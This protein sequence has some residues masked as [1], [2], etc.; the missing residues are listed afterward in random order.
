M[1]PSPLRTI[2]RK[3]ARSVSL[4]SRSHPFMLQFDEQLSKVRAS[5]ATTSTLSS[6][7]S[8]LAYLNNSYDSIDNIFLLPHIQQALSQER[9]DKCAAELLDGYLRLL[10]VCSTTRDLFS[11]KKQSIHELLSAL[12]RK[13]RDDLSRYLTSRKNSKKIIQKAL[14]E[15]DSIRSRQSVKATEKENT[16]VEILS[17]LKEVGTTTMTMFQS[18]LKHLN[19]RKQQTGWSLVSKLMNTRESKQEEEIKANELEKVDTTLHFLKDDVE[20]V[21]D[22]QNQLRNILSGIETVE[23][24][25][26]CL[27]RRLIKS[28]V[29]LLNILNH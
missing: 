23:D 22:V 9:Q 7:S 4:P 13:D 8:S 20:Q 12:R 29:F 2:I 24:D 10:D 21:E 6:V 17:M 5:E 3:P 16:T 19:G 11:Q 28:R 26:E 27:F 25:L 1:A 14:K 15:L 18:L